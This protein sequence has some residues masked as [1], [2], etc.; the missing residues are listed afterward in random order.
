MKKFIALLVS[1]GLFVIL[2][3]GC[4]DRMAYRDGELVNG[5]FN[6][7]DVACMMEVTAP[8]EE[9]YYMVEGVLKE[10]G[11]DELWMEA[12]GGQTLYFKLSPETIVYAGEEKKIKEGQ[13]VKVVFDAGTQEKQIKDLSVIAVSILEENF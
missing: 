10:M 11:K 8:I 7:D 2:S 4:A 5:G 1:C 6:S 13:A 3:A 12:K 9:G